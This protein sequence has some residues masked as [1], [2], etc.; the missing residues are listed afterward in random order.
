MSLEMWDELSPNLNFA[1]PSPSEV[2]KQERGDCVC[3]AE[4]RPQYIFDNGKI[5][6]LACSRWP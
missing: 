2:V 4:E 5:M 1:Q 6:T 3:G